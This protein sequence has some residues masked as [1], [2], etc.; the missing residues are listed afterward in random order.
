MLKKYTHAQNAGERHE[1]QLTTTLRLKMEEIPA[2]VLVDFAENPADSFEPSGARQ[3]TSWSMSSDPIRH[4]HES[5][6]KFEEKLR[7]ELNP[8][9]FF[10]TYHHATRESGQE[11]AEALFSDPTSWEINRCRN[12][13]GTN[14]Q[15][16]DRATAASRSLMWRAT[17]SNFDYRVLRSNSPP[18]ICMYTFGM[19]F[20]FL[21][22]A[23]ATATAN[24]LLTFPGPPAYVRSSKY[25]STKSSSTA[26]GF[27]GTALGGFSCFHE[28]GA[29]TTWTASIV[30]G[31]GTTSHVVPGLVCQTGDF[32]SAVLQI[33]GDTIF[34]EGG[35]PPIVC[36]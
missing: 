18:T 7:S 4:W 25:Q 36:I 22:A 1:R 20:L 8:D 33:N 10:L 34:L 14:N 21:M 6:Q 30:P 29:F 23:A 26:S 12:Q 13:G 31:S 27:T 15:S 9:N 17:R 28:N 19:K 16:D 11:S 3:R 2:R 5:G 32:C 24:P 35:P